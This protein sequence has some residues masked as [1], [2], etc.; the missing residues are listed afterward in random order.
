MAH[1]TFTDGDGVSWEVWDVF[2]GWADRRHGEDRREE[3]RGVRA[4]RRMLLGKRIGVR[5]ELAHGWLCFRGA[6]EKRRI[7]PIP[8]GWEDFDEAKLS[9][10]VRTL[11][12]TPDQSS[13]V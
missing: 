3:S 8:D 1:R 5:A 13:R 4:E 7:A 11:P 9:A 6:G 12:P 2:P 10:I